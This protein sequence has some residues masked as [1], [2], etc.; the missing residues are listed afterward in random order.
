MESE[1]FEDYKK[2]LE[3]DCPDTRFSAKMTWTVP[4]IAGQTV[5][6]Q[7]KFT[8]F[9]QINHW[10]LITFLW[11]YSVL[12]TQSHGLENQR[13]ETWFYSLKNNWIINNVKL[14]SIFYWRYFKFHMFTGF[15][16]QIKIF[17]LHRHS[18][19]ERLTF[20]QSAK[21]HL[22]DGPRSKLCDLAN[23]SPVHREQCDRKD[24]TRPRYLTGTDEG[25][26]PDPTD[27]LDRSASVSGSNPRH[28]L[29]PVSQ[30]NRLERHTWTHHER[31]SESRAIL[32]RPKQFQNE[33]LICI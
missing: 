6:Y 13:G 25:G 2:T 19:V 3:L 10:R 31:S 14:L 29:Y 7:V 32:E 21:R 4:N 8:H 9:L 20:S 18:N 16:T 17:K 26:T 11:I 33:F 5:Y 27:G 12:Q 15:D 1:T 30:S 24:K 22:T 28:K 23:W